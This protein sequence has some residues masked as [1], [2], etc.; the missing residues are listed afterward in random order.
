MGDDLHL[1]FTIGHLAA[2]HPCGGFIKF[3]G[4]PS[5]VAN[6]P[7]LE[8]SN[9]GTDLR[10]PIVY[11]WDGFLKIF[12]AVPVSIPLAAYITLTLSAYA[13]TITL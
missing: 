3:G 11:G 7:F 1:S 6:F 2:N 5:I 9:L 10:R 12:A 4:K 8:T 13:A